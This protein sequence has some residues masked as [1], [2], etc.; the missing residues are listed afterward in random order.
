MAP[1]AVPV[2]VQAGRGVAHYH[3][4]RPHQA[5]GNAPLVGSTATLPSPT[6][7]V[8]CRERLG[9]MLRSYARDAA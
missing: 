4:E 8:V 9:G 7:V 6:G 3:T 5:R 1:L 2:L